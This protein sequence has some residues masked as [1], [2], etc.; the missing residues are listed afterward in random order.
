MKKRLRGRK[1]DP[2]VLNQQED[3]PVDSLGNPAEAPAKK[4]RKLR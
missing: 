4:K 1:Y 2:I 3:Q